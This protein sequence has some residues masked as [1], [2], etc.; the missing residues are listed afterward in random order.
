MTTVNLPIGGAVAAV[1]VFFFSTP[2]HA[3]PAPASRKE[4][5]L[6]M[7]VAGALVLLAAFICF[8]LAMQWGGVTKAWSSADIIGLLVGAGLL[9]ILFVLLEFY[10]GEYAALNMRILRMRWV[11][12]N[13]RCVLRGCPTSSQHIGQSCA[14]LSEALADSSTEPLPLF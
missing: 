1:I 4:K 8:L 5:F 2:K 10:L 13:S 3:R 7:D 14:N 11:F 12:V 6:Q 9:A